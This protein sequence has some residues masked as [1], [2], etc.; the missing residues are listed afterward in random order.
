M[1]KT[2]NDAM[3]ISLFLDYFLSR[4]CQFKIFQPLFS[5]TFLKFRFH[6][7]FIN[8]QIFLPT[9]RLKIFKIQF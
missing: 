6:L 8:S 1:I 7:D 5:F 3:I 9:V 4:T 2:Q